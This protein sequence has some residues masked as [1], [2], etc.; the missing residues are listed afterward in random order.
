MQRPGS[1]DGVTAAPEPPATPPAP[2]PTPPGPTPPGPT[3][4][5]A[6]PG[7][8][9][10]GPTR[11][12]GRGRGHGPRSEAAVLG[13]VGALVVVAGVALMV[14]ERDDRGAPPGAASPT[15]TVAGPGDG[16]AAAGPIVGIAGVVGSWSGSA[17]QPVAAGDRPD[18]G[19][20]YAVVR[21]DEPLATVTG[22]VVAEECPGEGAGELDVD[23]GLEPGPDDEPPPVGVA[24][25]AKPRPRTVEVLDPG[26]A[27][28]RQAAV[29]VAAGLGAAAPPTL[30]QVLR[31]DLDGDGTDEVVVTAERVSDPEGLAPADGDYSLV[32]L[33]RVA[34]DGV[35]TSVV[36][37]SV[38]GVDPGLDRVRVS[39]LA[40][41]NG[42]G[43]MELVTS[44]ESASGAWTAVHAVDADGVPDEVLRAGCGA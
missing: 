34:G 43:V 22:R 36:V 1:D 39:A 44:G 10:L 11:G 6:T 19:V 13:V 3:P 35:A 27:T 33:R 16:S 23:L 14:V 21:L 7:P 15:S 26:S 40:D 25:V 32:F 30:A 42:D 31:S 2:G 4:P 24:G 9:P 29:E 28:Y 8:T 17:W 41:L 18:D 37:S 38:A 5:G 12:P 20:D